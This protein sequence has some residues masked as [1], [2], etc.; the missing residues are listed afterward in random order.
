M[1]YVNTPEKV[2]ALTI[3]FDKANQAK[4]QVATSMDGRKG[5]ERRV[6]VLCAAAQAACPEKTI[7]Q[8]GGGN[9]EQKL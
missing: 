9:N 5:T 6:R 8:G 4:P 2:V 7:K 3:T 1:D